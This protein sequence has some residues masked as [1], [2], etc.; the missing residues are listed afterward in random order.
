MMISLCEDF[1][2]IARWDTVAKQKARLP[3]NLFASYLYSYN[4]AFL[5]R[6]LF[7]FNVFWNMAFGTFFISYLNIHW[8]S[9]ETSLIMIKIN[10]FFSYSF[11]RSDMKNFLFSYRQIISEKFQNSKISLLTLTASI[12]SRIHKR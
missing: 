4:S 10:N 1:S 3:F 9:I 12:F 2:A 8:I 7:H 11:F 6:S 5:V